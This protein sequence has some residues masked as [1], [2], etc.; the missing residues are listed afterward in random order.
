MRGCIAAG[1]EH[2]SGSLA[3]LS[4]TEP[5][6]AGYGADQVA[7]LFDTES[8]CYDDA[9]EGPRADGLRARMAA[10]V[11]AVGPGPGDVLDAGMGPGRLLAELARLEWTVSGLDISERM[12]ALAVARLPQA[13]ERLLKGSITE[14]PFE[15]ASFDA[16]TATGVIEYLKDPAAGVGELLRV[17]RPGGLVVVSM[18]NLSSIKARWSELWYPSVRAVKRSAPGLTA[19]PAPFAKPGLMRLPDFVQLITTAGAAAVTVRHVG[20]KLLPP[21]FDLAAPVLQRRLAARLGTA[22]G[23][24]GSAL[25]TQVMVT[26]RKPAAQ[27]A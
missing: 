21:P 18:P 14:L 13:R 2:S 4:A 19:R 3:P 15:D 20:V 10:V 11:D 17:L 25:A 23:R 5:I 22:P 8:D 24:R 16:V 12:V 1:H 6:R 27:D 9:H 7:A 26:A